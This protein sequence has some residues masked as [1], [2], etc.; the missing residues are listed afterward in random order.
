MLVTRARAEHAEAVA[1]LFERVDCP[2]YCRYWDFQGDGRAWQDRCANDRAQSRAELLDALQG[3]DL[4]G[5]VAVEDDRVVG[6]MRLATPERMQK[7]Y[8][9]RLYRNLPCFSGDRSGVLAVACFLVD[10]ERRK[11]GVAR[12]LLGRAIELA[13]ESG[14]RSLE[15]FPRGAEDVSD[16]EH[17]LGPPRLY[18]EYGFEVVS[19]F[20]PYPVVRLAL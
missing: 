20:R 5:L 13:R 9:G 3:D 1:A 12:A 6:W 17:W 11:S 16:A 15:A 8:E 7:Q 18:A 4:F 14:A 10:E 2:C 19:D